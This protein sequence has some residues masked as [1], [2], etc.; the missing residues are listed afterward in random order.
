M[1]TADQH[2]SYSFLAEMNPDAK[3]LPQFHSAFIGV[4]SNG[5]RSVALYD[6]QRCI[7]DLVMNE[8]MR[9]SDAQSFLMLDII[10]QLTDDNSPMF[11]LQDTAVV[12]VI[13]LWE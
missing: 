8:N 3:I 5:L 4:A 12:E 9:R 13:N 10:S 6:H 2:P 11:V 7:L 1:I